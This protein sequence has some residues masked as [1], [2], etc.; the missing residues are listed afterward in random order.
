M[1]I[2]FILL[3]FIQ[4]WMS[5]AQDESIKVSQDGIQYFDGSTTTTAPTSN[6]TLSAK[7][8]VGVYVDY[9]NGIVGDDILGAF[10]ELSQVLQLDH[11]MFHD[12]NAAGVPQDSVH[13]R[14]FVFIKNS[15]S[16]T[17]DL[18][19]FF[20]DNT[21]IDN[22]VF[23]FFREDAGANVEFQRITLSN[24]KIKDIRQQASYDKTAMSF[25]STEKIYLIYQTELI[26]DLENGT[27]VTIPY[28]H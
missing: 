2:G 10:D 12:L 14:S 17:R 24:V 13:H 22:L 7:L 11:H 23:R 18:Y 15:D 4:S 27:S 16:A 6:V 20:K 19:S 1:R 9:S 3:F 28:S 26:E 25:T 5:V 21:K 8:I